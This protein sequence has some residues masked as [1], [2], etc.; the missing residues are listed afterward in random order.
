MDSL[1]SIQTDDALTFRLEKVVRAREDLMEDFEGPLD[2]ILFLLGKHKMKIE[3]LRIAQL[4]EQYMDWLSRMKAL[5][6]E[7]A[8]EF[9]AMASHLVYLKSKMLLGYDPD[10]PDEEVDALIAALEERRRREGAVLLEVGRAFLEERAYIARDLYCKPPEPVEVDRT[11]SRVHPP[12]ELVDAFCSIFARA[13]RR[14][15]PPPTVFSGIVG[16]EPFPVEKK[17]AVLLSML[18]RRDTLRL[19]S[20]WE[21]ASS[22]SELVATFL[23]VLEL[24]RSGQVILDDDEI[25]LRESVCAQEA[26]NAAAV[27]AGEQP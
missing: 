25:R 12:Q 7:V 1:A 2:L 22:R 4:L 3:D 26:N 17:I 23:A 24:C 6:L 13:K 11:Y 16:R 27:S 5:D 15:L 21:D 14:A 10:Q 18:S 19:P 9:I 20:L 8:S